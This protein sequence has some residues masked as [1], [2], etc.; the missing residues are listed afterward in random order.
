MLAAHQKDQLWWE[1]GWRGDKRLPSMS[2]KQT[3]I[4]TTQPMLRNAFVIPT[5][6]CIL[7]HYSNDLIRQSLFCLFVPYTPSPE[8]E[9]PEDGVY[10]VLCH[11]F[12]VP[13]S[14]MQQRLILAGGTTVWA[15]CTGISRKARRAL[16]SSSH[17][18]EYPADTPSIWKTNQSQSPGHMSVPKDNSLNVTPSHTKNGRTPKTL[19]TRNTIKESCLI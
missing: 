10:A 2:S 8:C 5:A 18:R 7:L 11:V 4:H 14:G 12:P 9:L 19:T 16:L 17:G 15:V 3:K 13:H 1:V 6:L